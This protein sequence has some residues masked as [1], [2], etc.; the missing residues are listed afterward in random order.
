MA[1]V[2]N[3][4]G[5]SYL[6]KE[7][8]D[9]LALP[10]EQATALD[11]AAALS[12][13][14]ILEDPFFLSLNPN[15]T[16]EDR[17]LLNQQ[18]G[19]N[20]SKIRERTMSAGEA[21]IIRTSQTVFAGLDY[22][23]DVLLN[24][25]MTG[26]GL[27]SQ[28]YEN[29]GQYFSALGK[30]FTTGTTIGQ[31]VDQKWKETFE[32]GPEVTLGVDAFISEDSTIYEGRQKALKEILGWDSDN[33][34]GEYA[35]IGTA[36]AS[37]LSGLDKDSAEA[38][39]I[40]G[41]TDM[42]SILVYFAS[43][44]GL[45]KG[46]VKLS[47]KLDKL[48]KTAGA[49]S[50][51]G[52]VGKQVKT[53]TSAADEL[54]E[55]KRIADLTPEQAIAETVAKQEADEALMRNTALDYMRETYGN[56]TVDVL[57]DFIDEVP[58]AT[59]NIA[60]F[61]KQVVGDLE[62]EGR[63]TG[64][65][66]ALESANANAGEIVDD[67]VKLDRV[68]AKIELEKMGFEAEALKIEFENAKEVAR[69]DEEINLLKQEIN[70]IDTATAKPEQAF[71]ETEGAVATPEQIEAGIA[72]AKEQAPVLLQRIQELEA[73]K[74][75]VNGNKVEVDEDGE[76][77]VAKTTVNKLSPEDKV[78]Y[79]KVQK[80][81]EA[82][83][84]N[85]TSKAKSL[86][87][88]VPSRLKDVDEQI[89]KAEK[90]VN[91]AQKSI[92]TIDEV[93]ARGTAAEV[94]DVRTGEV[95]GR[96]IP[97]DKPKLIKYAKSILNEQ[98]KKI[99]ELKAEK[100]DLE[101]SSPS[102]IKQYGTKEH[103]AFLKRAIRDTEARVNSSTPTSRGY[104]KNV[105]D[106][107]RYREELRVLKSTSD[108]AVI[109]R[110]VNEAAIPRV[111]EASAATSA[112][113]DLTKMK[114]ELDSKAK[115][116]LGRFLKENPHISRPKGVSTYD[117]V[118]DF[119][120]DYAG[121][122]KGVA[123]T[124]QVNL[125]RY[126]S[127]L[128]GAKFEKVLNTILLFNKHAKTVKAS[129]KAPENFGQLNSF[130]RNSVPHE[131]VVRMSKAE[132][133]DELKGILAEGIAFGKLSQK[134]AATR[135]LR[136]QSRL[137]DPVTGEYRTLDSYSE[138]YQKAFASVGLGTNKVLL[139]G[140]DVKN[141]LLPT[142]RA[143]DTRSSEDMTNG[144]NDM[145]AYA[146][147]ALGLKKYGEKGKAARKLR[148]QLVTR[149]ANA[150]SDE[151]RRT[152]WYQSQEEVI[153]FFTK[154]Y[155]VPEQEIKNIIQSWKRAEKQNRTNT[156]RLAESEATRASSVMLKNLSDE[157]RVMY[158]SIVYE[159]HMS[160]TVSMI[161]P[162]EM[163]LMLKKRESIE[164]YRER[165]SQQ[166]GA[167]WKLRYQESKSAVIN[168]Y[169]T[170]FKN[171]VLFRGGYV[172]RNT[173]ET[174]VRMYLKGHPSMLTN[175]FFVISAMTSR[176]TKLGKFLNEAADKQAEKTF[177]KWTRETSE[178]AGR[179]NADVTGT[180]FGLIRAEVAE[181]NKIE[182][183]LVQLEI[184]ASKLKKELKD[185]AGNDIE[186]AR[187]KKELGINYNEAK[188]LKA[189]RDELNINP[190]LEEAAVDLFN[191]A[192]DLGQLTNPGRGTRTGE[193]A[194][195][196]ADYV[197]IPLNDAK[198]LTAYVQ[199]I[200]RIMGD[201]IARDVLIAS[202]NK[203]LSREVRNYARERNIQDWNPEE[204]TLE[205]YWYGPGRVIVDAL[206]ES[207]LRKFNNA[208]ESLPKNLD[209]GQRA[210][211]IEAISD[212]YKIFET[213]D[214]F[215]RHLFDD[216]NPISYKSMVKNFTNNLQEEYVDVVI[217]NRFKKF[218]K[219]G[220]ETYD[221]YPLKSN[222]PNANVKADSESN[223]KELKEVFA[224]LIKEWKETGS[225]K[226]V[227]IPY[228]DV[229]ALH[230]GFGAK[231]KEGGL[232]EGASTKIYDWSS[233]AQ[234][235]F[236]TVPEFKFS[237]WDYV[238]RN[239]G[240]L[241][242]K[243]AE[244]AIANA[245]RILNGPGVFNRKAFPGSW[246]KR[247]LN[248]MKRNAKFAAADSNFNLEDLRSAANNFAAKEVEKLFY[249]AGKVKAF[250]HQLRLVA[251]F[252]QAWANSL[253]VWTKLAIKNPVQ[254]YKAEEVFEFL[255][256]EK[257]AFLNDIL[258]A[259][260]Y[261]ASQPLI[262]E[263]P[264]TG[265]KVIGVPLVGELVGLLTMGDANKTNLT[266]DI[267]SMNL[268]F[269]NGFLPGFGP[270]VQIPLS[271]VE[272]ISP[273]TYNMI[274][275]EI[276]N[277]IQ[278]Y[279]NSTDVPFSLE[280][281]LLPAYLKEIL[282]PIMFPEVRT[283][284]MSMAMQ[285][286]ILEHPEKYLD[287]DGGIS[288]DAGRRLLSDATALSNGLAFARGLIQFIA[289]GSTRIEGTFKDSNGEYHLMTTVTAEYFNLMNNGYDQSEAAAMMTAN[290]GFD[291]WVSMITTT[292]SGF[293]PTDEAYQVLKDNPDLINTDGTILSLIYPG[294]GY[295]ARLNNMLNNSNPLSDTELIENTN[296]TLAMAKQSNLD[297]MLVRGDITPEQHELD[298]AALNKSTDYVLTPKIDADWKTRNIG[299]L[300]DA[301]ENPA[302]AAAPSMKAF[303]TYKA[304]RDMAWESMGGRFSFDAE[305]NYRTRIQLFDIGT[306]LAAENKEFAVMWFR[307]LRSEVKPLNNE[308]TPPEGV[309]K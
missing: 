10:K 106:L 13:S 278:T 293:T 277:V 299:L 122:R 123:D 66:S 64:I 179:S 158:Q 152:V 244:K 260:D 163:R 134:A 38:R 90:L 225:A 226:I 227:T 243:E 50:S 176:Q 223:L 166:K 201:P 147:G 173:L 228:A 54:A 19:A 305:K 190:E 83:S 145:L 174:N 65:N 52:T 268:L 219:D 289:P 96:T 296:K 34:Y 290:Y 216:T 94:K 71:A 154:A 72:A 241:S 283:K 230:R 141:N 119:I 91:A 37:Q 67:V 211:R 118:S 194:I 89:I 183:E 46:G 270:I 30:S 56:E 181:F 304:Y 284:Y 200:R 161:D 120:N 93:I 114:S 138:A 40:A 102:S 212:E 185:N 300:E 88:A 142:M 41:T 215:A 111:R 160:H 92:D 32:N 164:S 232:F 202:T 274:P 177:S 137:L 295:S 261:D 121:L 282:A 18:A 231:V 250:A 55:A 42:A 276:K 14:K 280:S 259:G 68:T 48:L 182:D 15:I 150:N 273:A 301:L 236:A 209:E 210:A 25:G 157:E 162:Y 80:D 264:K 208:V 60:N 49:Q 107:S 233:A 78:I 51:L 170:T 47:S 192:S 275:D 196:G 298:S 245:E 101:L 73:R 116:I 213:R 11:N 180:S 266:I 124:Q 85:S 188:A 206:Y 75:M 27:A 36:V 234:K 140:L 297:A 105:E 279:V 153:Y 254:V 149:M 257:S 74:A 45:V 262:F 205:Y 178:R 218:D 272:K 79:D 151:L 21:S 99:K 186:V 3:Y 187:I 28:E 286:L 271:F 59:D 222:D 195:N 253:T 229:Q 87:S 35:S 240:M 100:K 263:D 95:I 291:A 308:L 126:L 86:K 63:T 255:N 43:A 1:K 139:W 129:G 29:S 306:Q 109:T 143:Y 307:V 20:Y 7:Q 23:G 82:T 285:Q 69:I 130:L 26:I 6:T 265:K 203:P 112:Q 207:N 309:Q 175:P 76:L 246:A 33:E 221:V 127:W 24:L 159:M 61:A 84:K 242:Q 238:A 128:L 294:G 165:L 97:A 12:E 256:S 70:N 269:Q 9:A 193:Q 292:R 235:T 8:L 44:T 191:E 144:V 133:I 58:E 287:K 184:K 288:D 167:E 247:T 281:S 125:D 156:Q 77:P 53:A 252:G 239:V 117:E 172:V 197:Q 214:E 248:E 224:P 303:A 132:T 146:F 62:A 237:H 113:Q 5:T 199:Y 16:N 169:D 103:A 258:A 251:P 108:E 17:Y 135:L 168:L 155:D 267:A 249:D 148:N 204:I 98:K 81:I 131:Y 220:N 22:A 110:Q 171:L 104:A 39:F 115:E 4:S 57:V 2:D 136:W 31:L 189:Q 198:F 302:L 217:Y